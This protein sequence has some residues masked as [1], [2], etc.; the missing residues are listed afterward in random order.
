MI[1]AKS[2][3]RL[4]VSSWSSLEI[5]TYQNIYI[6]HCF[7]YFIYHFREVLR[8]TMRVQFITRL[9]MGLTLSITS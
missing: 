9:S 7:R 8:Y 2:S 6:Y 4:N 3:E 5:E 1:Q